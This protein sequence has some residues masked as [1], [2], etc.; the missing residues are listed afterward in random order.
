MNP[1]CH[2]LFNQFLLLSSFRSLYAQAVVGCASWETPS[3]AGSSSAACLW[4]LA[5]GV[6]ANIWKEREIS[7][8]ER[9]VYYVQKQW[10]NPF[11]AHKSLPSSHTPPT[12]AHTH[13]HTHKPWWA[14]RC[15][16][17]PVAAP[18]STASW[19]GRRW[20]FAVRWSDERWSEGERYLGREGKVSERNM[21][22]NVKYRLITITEEFMWSSVCS[23]LR[24]YVYVIKCFCHT[25]CVSSCTCCS[26]MCT[27]SFFLLRQSLALCRFFSNLRDAIF[28]SDPT[29]K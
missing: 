22:N 1:S 7:F 20:T 26:S 14:C 23:S 24:A 13:T 10:R 17:W 16:R 9:T 18:S 5:P 8:C 15:P 4:S 11:H 28:N 29:T 25:C 2:S 12:S 6:R 3:P 19:W 21:W 27:F